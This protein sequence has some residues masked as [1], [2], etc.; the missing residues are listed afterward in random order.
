MTDYDNTD[1]ESIEQHDHLGTDAT[2]ADHYWDK[3][4]RTIYVVADGAIDH[5]QSIDD[6]PL[7]DWI[8][9]IRERR[10]WLN[11]KFA[12]GGFAEIVA[13]RVEVR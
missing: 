12:T 6:R 10:G 8:A 11:C 5:E 13:E 4:S 7:S 1:L 9:Y 2:G 3:A